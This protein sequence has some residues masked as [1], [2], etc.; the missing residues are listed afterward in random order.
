MN[1]TGRQARPSANATGTRRIRKK[2]NAP[3][4]HIAA[5]AGVSA[6]PVI[7]DPPEANCVRLP[8]GGQRPWGGPAGAEDPPEA[9]CVRR[10][11]RGQRAWGG[12]AGAE[13][14]P[15]AN[16]VRLP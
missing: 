5:T 6:A 11:P 16:C 8:P 10:R 14:P 15:E 3:N 2:K 1:R 9:N 4:S 12:P 13:D 7:E